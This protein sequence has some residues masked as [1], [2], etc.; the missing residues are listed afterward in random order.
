MAIL[1]T[2][3]IAVAVLP[4]RVW[5]GIIVRAVSHATGRQARIDGDVTVRLLSLQP[6]LTVEGFSLANA[7]GAGSPQLLTLR[8]LDVSVDV[9]SLFR[10]ELTFPY[11]ILEAPS[12]DLERNSAGQVNWS[13]TGASAG[14]SSGKDSPHAP[15]RHPAA[16]PDRRPLDP[17]R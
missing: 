11:L 8:R 1:V 3:V 2:A 5:R 4:G 10:G 7:T 9:W 14:K 15:S 17:G 12:L 6:R 13:F 16:A